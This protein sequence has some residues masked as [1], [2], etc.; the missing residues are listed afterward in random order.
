MATGKRGSSS[1]S[2]ANSPECTSSSA[3]PT[4]PG[5]KRIIAAEVPSTI[6]TD[7]TATASIACGN[8]A[9]EM[10]DRNR[11]SRNAL[12]PTCCAMITPAASAQATTLRTGCRVPS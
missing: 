2:S 7:N 9:A 8:S 10:R 1:H 5:P 3:A 11:P 12:L 6:G 4:R